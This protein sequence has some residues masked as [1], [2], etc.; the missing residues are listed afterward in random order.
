MPEALI[1][2]PLNKDV[3][4]DARGTA[5]LVLRGDDRGYYGKLIGVNQNGIELSN[6]DQV[7]RIYFDGPPA[8][9]S[10]VHGPPARTW[11]TAEKQLL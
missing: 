8:F 11:E 3:F 4:K 10:V 9:Y 6:G 7:Q 1:W 5:I 2:R